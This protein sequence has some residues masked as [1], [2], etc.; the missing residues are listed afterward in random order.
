MM[1][2]LQKKYNWVMDTLYYDSIEAL[3]KALKS[4]IIDPALEKHNELRLIK[5]TES[6]I[7]SAKDFLDK[8]KE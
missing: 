3:I 1:V 8:E 5:A 7:P 6:K 2:D 4:A